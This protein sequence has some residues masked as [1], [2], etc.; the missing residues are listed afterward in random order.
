MAKDKRPVNVQV[1]ELTA[2]QRKSILRIGLFGTI[3][4]LLV[5]VIILV[6]AL[7]PMF[8]A[9]AAVV[10]AEEDYYAARDTYEEAEEEW[11]EAN[12]GNSLMTF[13]MTDQG[14]HLWK[15][16]G[17]ALDAWNEAGEN[18]E[19]KLIVAAIALGVYILIAVAG[20][21]CIYKKFPYYSDRKCWYILFHR[22]ELSV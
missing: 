14:S 15:E 7:L 12:R 2:E 10:E 22:K 4:T 13:M 3:A 17:E 21:T 1:A 5:F 6:V 18:E 19:Q 20:F 9:R 8:E 16:S 11:K